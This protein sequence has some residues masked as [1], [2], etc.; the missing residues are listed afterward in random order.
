MKDK[1]PCPQQLHV[2]YTRQQIADQ[3]GLAVEIVIRTLLRMNKEGKIK[4]C[5]HKL[6]Y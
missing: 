5:K 2:P 1:S 3:T 4:I 6:Y